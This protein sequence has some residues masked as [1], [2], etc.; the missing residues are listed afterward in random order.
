MA[1]TYCTSYS[2]DSLHIKPALSATLARN[3]FWKRHRLSLPRVF[4]SYATQEWVCLGKRLIT[5][6]ITLTLPSSWLPR[7]NLHRQ[8]EGFQG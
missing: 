8:T 4:M 2:V 7:S 3:A 1:S 6:A 5:E